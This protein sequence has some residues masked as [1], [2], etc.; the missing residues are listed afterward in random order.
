MR[1]K[2]GIT[3]QERKNEIA[4]WLDYKWRQYEND[5]NR[6]FTHN[7]MAKILGLSASTFSRYILGQ[8]IPSIRNACYIAEIYG[9]DIFGLCGYPVVLDINPK[10]VN[11][12]PV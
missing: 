7:K 4:K 10:Q 11:A 9:N 2:T 6:R 3:S 12:V 1:K 5:H 8:S